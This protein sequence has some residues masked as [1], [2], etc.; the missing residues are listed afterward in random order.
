MRERPSK[1]NLKVNL[2]A[3]AACEL[4]GDPYTLTRAAYLV[5]KMEDSIISTGKRWTIDEA[6]EIISQCVA[7]H[8]E[9]TKQDGSLEDM[10]T[11]NAPLKDLLILVLCGRTFSCSATMLYDEGKQHASDPIN[12]IGSRPDAPS[13]RPAE[14]S[15]DIA[16]G[17]YP[18]AWM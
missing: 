17:D 18:P 12:R 2:E 13:Y 7:R 9:C 11:V 15:V 10:Y 14:S 3:F 4:I 8:T 1:L 6:N 16:A 5:M